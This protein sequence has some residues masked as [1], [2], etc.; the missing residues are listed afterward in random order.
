MNKFFD[1]IGKVASIT[2]L[3]SG[4][5]LAGIAACLLYTLPIIVAGTVLIGIWNLIT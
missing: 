4:V 1:F 3:V 5:M 2:L